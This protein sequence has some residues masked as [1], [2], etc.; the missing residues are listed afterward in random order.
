MIGRIRKSYI[1]RFLL[2]RRGA[3]PLH[4]TA[5]RVVG[6]LRFRARP[7]FDNRPK[8]GFPLADRI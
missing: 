6:S 5:R 8:G 7:V 1:R 4:V 2:G 3:R